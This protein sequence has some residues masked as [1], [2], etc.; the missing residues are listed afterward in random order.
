MIE[1]IFSEIFFEW[2]ANI[3]YEG[4]ILVLFS[5]QKSK[6]ADFFFPLAYS[7]GLGPLR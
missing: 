7:R 2:F 6:Y 4:Q 5:I 1:N 3:F